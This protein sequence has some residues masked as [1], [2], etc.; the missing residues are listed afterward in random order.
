MADYVNKYSSF[1]LK[2]QLRL[3]EGEKLTINCNDETVAFAHMVAKEAADITGVDVQVVYIEKG[4]VEGVEEVEAPCQTKV[5]KGNVMLHLASFPSVERGDN[6]DAKTLSEMR[7][8]SDPIFLDRKISIPWATVYVPTMKWSRFVYGPEGTEDTLWAEI[9]DLLNLDGEGQLDE[10]SS[11]Q[12]YLSSKAEGIRRH[13]FESLRLISPSCDL[14][15]RINASSKPIPSAVKLPSGRVF[16]PFYPSEDISI[17]IDYDS[18]NGSFETTLPFRLYDQIVE[19]ARVEL[20]DGLV[21]VFEAEGCNELATRFLNIDTFTCRAGEIIL[22]SDYSRSSL[23]RKS[24]AL[25]QF[26]RM[27]TTSLVLGGVTPEAIELEADDTVEGKGINTGFARLEL[28]LG[29]KELDVIGID[30]IGNETVIMEEGNFSSE[31]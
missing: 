24:L 28:P 17:P 6:D 27:R 15:A 26:D 23:L 25:P 1:I 9:A 8:L 31:L 22:A 19:N 16:Y 12:R 4:K 7:L 2:R 10:T 13:N 3:E 18:A 14:S 5:R 20:K 29:S 11:L 21:S 30:A